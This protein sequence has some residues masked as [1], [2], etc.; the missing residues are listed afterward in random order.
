MTSN[1]FTPCAFAI[2]ASLSLAACSTSRTEG[3][4]VTVPADVSTGTQLATDVVTALTIEASDSGSGIAFGTALEGAEGA[5]VLSDT[6][7][8]VDGVEYT[9]VDLQNPNAQLGDLFASELV[10][11]EGVTA[12]G[13]GEFGVLNEQGSDVDRVDI[14]FSAAPTAVADLPTSTASYTGTFHGAFSDVQDQELHFDS[15]TFT[16]TADFG[17]AQSLNG[18]FRSADEDGVVRE[19]ATLDADIS[20]NTFSGVIGSEDDVVPINAAGYFTGDNASGLVGAGA[21]TFTHD[22]GDT[23]AVIVFEGTAQ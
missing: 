3:P 1:R 18:S 4:T 11:V 15:G 19:Q 10:S 17:A 23:E 16:A 5:P 22:N 20:G 13:A 8:T 7:Y 14:L 9:L 21:G 6:T 2:L 12:I